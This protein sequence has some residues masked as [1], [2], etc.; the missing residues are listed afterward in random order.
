MPWSSAQEAAA[1]EVG[2]AAAQ[3]SADRADRADPGWTQDA[4]EC[5]RAQVNSQPA[6][7][8]F[9]IEELRVLIP[10]ERLPEPPDKRAWGAVTRAAM[11]EGLIAPT[12][13]YRANVLR[14]AAPGA[15]YRAGFPLFPRP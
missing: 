8:V 3:A 7:A 10:P 14:H 5:L 4:L 15:C 11:R 13:T 1:R 6:G 9:T 12:G 2:H